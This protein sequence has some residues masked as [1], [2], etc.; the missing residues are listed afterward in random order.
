MRLFPRHLTRRRM[1]VTAVGVLALAGAAAS[2]TTASSTASPRA[3]TTAKRTSGRL[4]TAAFLARW[5]RLVDGPAVTVATE[6]GGG[7][8]G[9]QAGITAWTTPQLWAWV[10]TG[11]PPSLTGLVGSRV[12]ATPTSA[13]VDYPPGASTPTG[14]QVATYG[15][16]DFAVVAGLPLLP[17][18]AALDQPAVSLT[19]PQVVSSTPTAWRVRFTTVTPVCLS[20]EATATAC[21]FGGGSYGPPPTTQGHGQGSSAGTL[22][23]FTAT[24]TTAGGLR[25]TNGGV[26]MTVTPACLGRRHGCYA[27][28][29]PIPP[30]PAV[31][32]P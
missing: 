7:P 32:A 9:G 30:T 13:T 15:P 24:P 27:T 31:P 5:Q 22:Y 6:P 8:R 18:M 29:P 14:G 25:L 17:G 12:E 26:T 16:R 19:R 28:W 10:V 11:E 2:L 3:V 1:V 4:T 20:A 21:H 23:T